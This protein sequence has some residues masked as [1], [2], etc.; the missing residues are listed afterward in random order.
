MAHVVRA[1]V[2]QFGIGVRLEED[3]VAI[4]DSDGTAGLE[5]QVMRN[6]MLVGFVPTIPGSA[7]FSE[8]QVV[9]AIAAADYDSPVTRSPS[10]SAPPTRTPTSSR[11]VR[12]TPG[13]DPSPGGVLRR[14]FGGRSRR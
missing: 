11:P 14:L 8:D 9:A 3:R 6:G 12:P 1:G 2:Y 7:D 13:R 10:P 4:W 5:A